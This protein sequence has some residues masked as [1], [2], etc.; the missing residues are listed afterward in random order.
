MWVDGSY[1]V[2]R[3]KDAFQAINS[4]FTT[5]QKRTTEAVELSCNIN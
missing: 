3:Y 2:W 1:N 4:S 5:L